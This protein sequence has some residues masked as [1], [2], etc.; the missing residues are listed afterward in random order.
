MI[1]RQKENNTGQWIFIVNPVAGSGKA[2]KSWPSIENTL[3]QAGIPLEVAFT[4]R[5]L[6]AK[7][8]AMHAIRKGIRNIVAVGGDGTA[9][10]VINGIFSQT[11]CPT[12]EII[13]TVL[14][15]GTGNDWIK[16]HR[17]PKGFRKWLAF[18]A[19]QNARLHDVGW[20]TYMQGGGEHKRYFIN[21]A[22][23]SYDG[24]V[25]RESDKYK[26]WSSNALLYLFL[27]F[28]CL[29]QFVIPR[30]KLVADQLSFSDYFYTINIG[31]CRYSGG[32]LQLVPQANPFEGKLALTL[33]RRVSKLGVVLA[34]PL[35]Y[36][37][38]IG[39]HPA[40]SLHRVSEVK[41][42]PLDEQ[43]VLLEADGEFLGEAPVA[44]GILPQ[45]LQV[46]VP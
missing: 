20:L 2:R 37:G 24:Y 8:I 30:T 13:F 35:F 40:T 5:K 23:L 19:R 38:K 3:R 16:T 1:S 46:L 32:G 33:I 43:P 7:E 9:N 15:I 14:P 29:F 44:V 26:S 42:T 10:E 28:R 6:H 45:S 34:M 4:Q 27:I 11:E 18:F 21:V 36:L 39:I 12:R 17:I 31:V 22:G 25:A 41:I